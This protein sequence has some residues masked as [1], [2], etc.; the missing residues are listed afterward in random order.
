MK[1]ICISFYLKKIIYVKNRVAGF[2]HIGFNITIRLTT[3]LGTYFGK[4]F[5]L[6][7]KWRMKR[8]VS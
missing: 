3:Y 5:L 6:V 4:K 8:H 2:Y 1:L 7:K